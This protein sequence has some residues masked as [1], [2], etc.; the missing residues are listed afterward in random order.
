VINVGGKKQKVDKVAIVA[1]KEA[2]H[3]LLDYCPDI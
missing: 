2:A 1:D 3:A